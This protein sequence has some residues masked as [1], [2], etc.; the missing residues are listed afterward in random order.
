MCSPLIHLEFK[1]VFVRSKIDVCAILLSDSFY[2]MIGPSDRPK[3]HH[4]S[5]NCQNYF[6]A[7]N[8]LSK[9]AGFC[10]I[11]PILKLQLAVHLKPTGSHVKSVSRKMLISV[12]PVYKRHVRLTR[13]CGHTFRCFTNISDNLWKLPNGAVCNSKCSLYSLMSQ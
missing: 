10:D 6:V 11:P 1:I 7:F 12:F 5:C 8:Q 9:G 13:K 4:L 2:C 3:S